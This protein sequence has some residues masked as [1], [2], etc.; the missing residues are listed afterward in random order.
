MACPSGPAGDYGGRR[1]VKLRADK[2]YFSVEH[3]TQL[4][5]IGRVARSTRPGIESGERLG[6]HRWKIER[7]IA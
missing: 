4:R 1:P 5:E 7:S 3:L 6:R 2:A